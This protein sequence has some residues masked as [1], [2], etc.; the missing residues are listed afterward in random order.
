[1]AVLKSTLEV[2]LRDRAS[3]PG[4]R[5]MGLM[6]RLRGVSAGAQR[7]LSTGPLG[8]G[9]VR[10]LA[11]FGGAYVGFDQTVGAA[12][13][14]NEAMADVRKVLDPTPAEMKKLRA[15]VLGLSKDLTGIDATG[16]AEI[17]AEAGQAGI[18]GA[19]LERFTKFTAQAAVAFDLAARQA[20][21]VF[22]KAGNV[23]QFDQSQLEH[24]AD[25]VNHLSNNMAAKAPEIL[26]FTNRAAGS[27]KA[28]GLS[29][30]YLAAMGSSMIALGSVPESAGRAM[31]HFGSVVTKAEAGD[32]KIRRIFKTLGLTFEEWN[33][34]KKE[35]G[36]K[37][38]QD[39]FERLKSSPNGAKAIID[40]FGADFSKDFAKIVDNPQ[41]LARAFRLAGEEA[42]IAGSV[43]AEYLNKV[44]TPLKKLEKLKNNIAAIGIEIGDKIAVPLGNVA[45]HYADLLSTMDSRVDVFDKVGKAVSSFMEGF[46]GD[47]KDP[48]GAYKRWY[49]ELEEM[50]FGKP[51]TPDMTLNQIRNLEKSNERSLAGIGD[52]FR[53]L[54]EAVR[55]MTGGEVIGGLKK[56]SEQLK[57]LTSIGGAFGAG[58]GLVSLSLGLK[59]LGLALRVGFG[60]WGPVKLV[61]LAVGISAIV[62][63]A[64]NAGSV[65]EF[66]E[67]LKGLST[68]E[69]AGVGLTLGLVALQIGKVAA[70][71]RNA[72]KNLR[73]LKAERTS[74]KEQPGQ[75]R[76]RPRSR[77]SRA[78]SKPGPWEQST[79]S[80]HPRPRGARPSGRVPEMPRPERTLSNNRL[81]RPGLPG[82]SVGGAGFLG[83]L[84]AYELL[85]HTGDITQT[86]SW[87]QLEEGVRK[88][89]ERLKQVEEAGAA[90]GDL[91]G[92][93]SVTGRIGAAHDE[94][95]ST[96]QGFPELKALLER[97]ATGA[98]EVKGGP[99]TTQPSGVQDVHMTNPPPRPNINVTVHFTVHEAQDAEALVRE[100]GR[101]LR[102]MVSGVQAD[103]EATPGY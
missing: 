9:L 13:R 43:Q 96:A 62:E 32:Q 85:K 69:L 86:E 3:G 25:T 7:T 5:L 10:R 74:P 61:A 41:L 30:E 88:A 79:Q 11:A 78:T 35:N 31:T 101:R 54:G 103:I 49:R 72:V 20:G 37:A 93:L 23:F 53:K 14:F 64:S 80:P 19:R 47:Q 57:G 95:Q 16:L 97:M 102:D 42:Q 99:V 70:R 34:L 36:P 89:G 33:K 51:I 1:M 77:P 29:A 71:A 52:R 40:L 2:G 15:Q 94:A 98:Q 56:F 21:D 83:G 84:G 24:Y 22:A 39:L 58:L 38:M 76:P 75:E 26:E 66:A 48:F 8:A 67:A 4:R 59:A 46:S 50:I 81:S 100:A 87:K 90:I 82:G 18:A 60:L 44:D 68:L 27:A 91:V 92:R 63:A 65:S 17:M 73:N 45:K 6:Q 28:L 55:Q 12:M